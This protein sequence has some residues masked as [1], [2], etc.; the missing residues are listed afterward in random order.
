VQFRS[1]WNNVF[2]TQISQELLKGNACFHA[3]NLCVHPWMT[4]RVIG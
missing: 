2:S 3:A 1:Y 4:N